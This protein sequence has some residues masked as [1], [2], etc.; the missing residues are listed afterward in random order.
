MGP[1]LGREAILDAAVAL[2]AEHGVDGVT[3]A[4]INKASGHRN[5]S[6]STYHFG[7]KE[8]LIR[9]VVTGILLDHDARRMKLYDQLEARPE[10]STL[11][12]LLRVSLTP[13]VEDIMTPD[14]RLRVRVLANVTG[15]GR[16]IEMIRDVM[17]PAT[18]LERSMALSTAYLTHLSREMQLERIALATGF[19]VMAFADRARLI[20]S[21]EPDLDVLAFSEHILVLL[22]ALLAAPAPEVRPGGW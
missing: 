21:T 16:F 12:D 15:D 11:T 18:S 6:A 14:G 19:G 3:L 22:E 4:D 5:R 9:A 10:P 13:L 1:R 7:G 17:R 8:E 20:D 2:F